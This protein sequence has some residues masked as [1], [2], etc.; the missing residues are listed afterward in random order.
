MVTKGLGIL[1][2]PKKIGKSPKQEQ[3]KV[4][5]WEENGGSTAPKN[6]S[7]TQRV[8]FFFPLVSRS[9]LDSCE[10]E[11]LS[12]GSEM[13]KSSWF[14]FSGDF[15]F[16]ALLRYLL[17]II[18]FLKASGRQIQAMGFQPRPSNSSGALA[19]GFYVFSLLKGPVGR[20]WNR[21]FWV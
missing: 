21:V 20:P 10:L 17:G 5:E 3:N 13:G 2:E 15:L 9:D 8:S 11:V 6:G 14:C 4:K 16:L 7:K 1:F 12:W 19:G 18:I